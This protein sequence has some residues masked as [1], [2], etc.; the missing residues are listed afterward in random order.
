L[1]SFQEKFPDLLILNKKTIL[2]YINRFRA[3]GSVIDRMIRKYMLPEEK[4]DETDNTLKASQRKS[5]VG[6][7]QQRGVSA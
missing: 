4:L 6:I 2:K 5:F 3:T 1:S 7:K